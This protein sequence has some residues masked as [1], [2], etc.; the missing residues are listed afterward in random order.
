MSSR[1]LF[2]EDYLTKLGL[3][4]AL[5]ALDLMKVIMCAENGYK[6][7]NGD[8]Y[9]YHLVDVAQDLLSHGV[10]YEP[11]IVA[12]LL[13]D[14]ME[15]VPGV[16]FELI[17]RQFG[18][19]VAKY[20]ELLS[21]NPNVDYSIP[22]NLL[23]YLSGIGQ[24]VWTALIKTA[25]RKHNFST[26]KD[27]SFE[28]RM[29]QALETEQFFIPVFKQWRKAYVRWASYFYGAKTAI[30]PHLWA[31]KEYQTEIDRLKGKYALPVGML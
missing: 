1:V 14:Y 11:C 10:R 20:V 28:K 19:E 18:F 4:E 2:L 27:A 26:L 21:K 30:E 9:Y 17:E 16:T 6:R 3:T 24:H 25:D 23:A 5:K 29:K 8:H 15:D 13:H 7:H 22:S 12:A 31:I